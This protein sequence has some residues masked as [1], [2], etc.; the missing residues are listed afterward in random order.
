MST[1]YIYIMTNQSFQNDTVKIGYT[2]DVEARRKQLSTTAL[3]E[4]SV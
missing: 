3:P 4:S 2:T 1:G